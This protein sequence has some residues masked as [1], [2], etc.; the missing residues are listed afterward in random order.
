M[1][2]VL[3]GRGLVIGA[4]REASSDEVEVVVRKREAQLR[5]IISER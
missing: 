5:K 3:I 2:L 4:D 1:A